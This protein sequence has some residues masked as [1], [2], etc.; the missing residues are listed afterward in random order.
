MKAAISTPL[1]CPS[2]SAGSG[3]SF[4]ASSGKL[5]ASHQCQVQ[6]ARLLD[7]VDQSSVPIYKSSDYDP[8]APATPSAR[9]MSWI[10]GLS[11]I[12][13]LPP[14]VKQVLGRAHIPRGGEDIGEESIKSEVLD[15]DVVA[16]STHSNKITENVMGQTLGDIVCPALMFDTDAQGVIDDPY[17]WCAA[18]QL[19]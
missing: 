5:L 16:S 14:L 10:T 1:P 17:F 18:N 15:N 7:V 9:T 3:E 8:T 4:V 19:C 2:A 6:Q 11:L 12:P 13:K